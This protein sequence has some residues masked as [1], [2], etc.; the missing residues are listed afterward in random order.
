MACAALVQVG[1]AR[2]SFWALHM[3][4]PGRRCASARGCCPRRSEVQLTMGRTRA[5]RGA[6]AARP[7][8][9]ERQ[10]RGARPEP[11]GGT[12]LRGASARTAAGRVWTRK[13]AGIPAQR[14]ARARRRPA[15]GDRGA[16]RDRR[17]R[18]P[19]RAGDRVALERRRRPRQRRAGARMEPRQRRQRPAERLRAGGLGRR[20]PRRGPAGELRRRTSRG[21]TARTARE[22]RFTAEAERS[23]R[24]NLLIVSSDYRAPFGTFSGTLP[25]GDRARPGLGRGRAPPRALVGAQAACE[26]PVAAQRGQQQLGVHRADQLAQRLDARRRRSPSR[27]RPRPRRRGGRAARA[28]PPR[29]A[30]RAPRGSAGCRRR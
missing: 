22:L 21:S 2:Q 14:H 24:E 11:R 6:G 20:R 15:A 17:H 25:G 3:T 27:A 4:R 28:P 7:R 29:R 26:E 10:G 5:R 9:R 13:Q 30:A 8:A 1:P 16:G 23:R 18:R 19:P 12:G